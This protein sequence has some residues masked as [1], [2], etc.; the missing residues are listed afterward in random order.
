MAFPQKTYLLCAQFDI[1][2]HNESTCI[3]KPG[4]VYLTHEIKRDTPVLHHFRHESFP[5]PKRALRQDFTIDKTEDNT[6]ACTG[7]VS[8][9]G[10]NR[11]K[12]FLENGSHHSSR[13]TMKE[14]KSIWFDTEALSIPIRRLLEVDEVSDVVHRG[15]PVYLV[16]GVKLARDLKVHEEETIRRA[17]NTGLSVG[18]QGLGPVAATAVSA[19]LNLR[20]SGSH[21]RI[22]SYG[23]GKGWVVFAYQVLKVTA[24]RTEMYTKRAYFQDKYSRDQGHTLRATIVPKAE[25]VRKEDVQMVSG[26]L[27]PVRCYVDGARQAGS[28]EDVLFVQLS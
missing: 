5:P 10:W 17:D 24:R 3:V 19:S 9:F 4:N 8:F 2:A 21:A 27:R 15:N 14:L 18:F 13:Y 1:S 28:S 25:E 23:V 11:E 12:V 6:T 7:G 22:E 26:N 16:T 20:G